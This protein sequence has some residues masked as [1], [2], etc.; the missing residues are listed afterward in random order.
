MIYHHLQNLQNLTNLKNL[1]NLQ[2]FYL[3]E[4]ALYSL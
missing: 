4:A 1:Q 3:R 2:Y